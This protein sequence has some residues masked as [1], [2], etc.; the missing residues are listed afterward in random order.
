MH[1]PTIFP[2]V[3]ISKH[4]K[5]RIKERVG[6]K[7]ERDIERFIRKVCYEGIPLSRIP[8][9]NFNLFWKYLKNIELKAQESD[10]LKCIIVFKEY[11]VVASRRNGEVITVIKIKYPYTNYYSRI[12]AHIALCRFA[13]DESII[14]QSEELINT[15]GKSVARQYLLDNG[16]S[17][18]EANNILC[19]KHEFN[20]NIFRS[21]T[22]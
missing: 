21:K 19:K 18:K 14:K 6:V 1:L 3:S 22:F 15:K 11:I 10:E 4:A 7:S 5:K 9:S 16:C 2:R 8:K 20:L 12:V 13:F 17:P